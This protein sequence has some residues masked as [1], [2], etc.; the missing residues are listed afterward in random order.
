MTFFAGLGTATHYNIA[1]IYTNEYTTE[2]HQKLYNFI[3]LFFDNC[4]MVMLGIYF[5]FV[6]SILPLMYFLCAI[7]V[8]GILLGF[9]LPESPY[10]AYA[11]GQMEV[12]K[13]SLKKIAS[14]NGV[15]VDV[16]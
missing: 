12:F 10:F 15:D 3:G 4:V 5:Y 9:Y 14:F 7:H 1:M 16:D 11:T 6:K 13:A 8:Y 2:E